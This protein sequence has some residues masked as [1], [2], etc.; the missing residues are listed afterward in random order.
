MKFFTLPMLKEAVRKSSDRDS[1]IQEIVHSMLEK[2]LRLGLSSAVPLDTLE[3]FV[4]AIYGDITE[5]IY[6]DL[7]A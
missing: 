1:F 6:R 5:E 7:K 3:E 2:R 4:N